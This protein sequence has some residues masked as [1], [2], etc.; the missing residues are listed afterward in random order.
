MQKFHINPN[1][2]M[3][4]SSAYVTAKPAMAMKKKRKNVYFRFNHWLTIG[5]EIKNRYKT[6]TAYLD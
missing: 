3:C 6:R 2:A 5:M 1:C 4:S